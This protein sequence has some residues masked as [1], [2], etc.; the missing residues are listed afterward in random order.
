MSASAQNNSPIPEENFQLGLSRK[1]PWTQLLCYCAENLL[2]TLTI[3]DDMKAIATP[4]LEIAASK[5]QAGLFGA[6][7]KLS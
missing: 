3:D 5:T 2:S 1:H 4:L 6:I 7:Q